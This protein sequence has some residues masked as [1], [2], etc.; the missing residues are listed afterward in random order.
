[1][2][3]SSSVSVAPPPRGTT[4]GLAVWVSETATRGVPEAVLEQAAIVLTDT[5]ACVH[6][7]ADLA[8]GRIVAEV[9]ES[10]G[11]SDEATSLVTG[12][13]TSGASAAFVNATAGN[14]ADLDD[15]LLYHVHIASTVTAAALAAAEAAG[16]PYRALLTAIAL[17]YEVAA[18]IALS[19]EGIGR[20]VSPPPDLEVE[21]PPTFGHSGNALGAAAA[22]ASILGL[23]PDALRDAIGIAAYAAP[24]P[25][26]A[27]YTRLPSAPLNRYAAY[28][29][30]AWNGVVASRLAQAGLTGDREVLDGDA[31]FWQMAGSPTV[32]AS[33]LCDGLG[34]RWWILETSFKREAACTWARPAISAARHLAETVR[35]RLDEV[36]RIVVRTHALSSTPMFLAAAPDEYGDAQMSF[37]FAV[38]A[39]LA[40][41]PEVEWYRREGIADPTVRDLAARVSIERDPAATAAVYE[42]IREGARPRRVRR[43]P[44]VV[45]LQV[46]GRLHRAIAEYGSGDPVDDVRFG[47]D[48]VARKLRD[49]AS[50]RLGDEGADRAARTLLES[51]LDT[52]V[53]SI[54]DACTPSRSVV[55]DRK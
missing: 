2:S 14:V 15:N 33:A 28:G 24:V 49:H 21:W 17:G 53:R 44:T 26:I 10:F 35:P 50:P 4:E 40:G 45:E 13:R 47:P 20:V 27:K 6:A 54:V 23:G 7:G 41:L 42:Q 5:V 48:D 11:G 55:M 30:M 3:L 31:G 25:S 12:R 51:P 38:A 52:P 22:A 8:G 37:P 36:E 1:M 16:A 29:W 34:T 19:H 43:L 39:A 46:R 32:D 9:I 18:R